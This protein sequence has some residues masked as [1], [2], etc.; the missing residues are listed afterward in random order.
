MVLVYVQL[1]LCIVEEHSD[2]AKSLSPELKTSN[3]KLSLVTIVVYLFPFK[4]CICYNFALQ[5]TSVTIMK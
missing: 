4:Y 3:S 2:I 5:F 1:F